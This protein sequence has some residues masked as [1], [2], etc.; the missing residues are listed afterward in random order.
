MTPDD[1]RKIYKHFSLFPENDVNTFK[2]VGP[3]N[4][5]I[6]SVVN[7]NPSGHTHSFNIK[8]IGQ[9]TES[10]LQI[11]KKTGILAE[12]RNLFNDISKKI[13]TLLQNR[14]IDH[15][16]MHKLLEC[17]QLRSILKYTFNDSI[18]DIDLNRWFKHI[19]QM[20][21]WNSQTYENKNINFSVILDTDFLSDETDN[22]S[23]QL[24]NFYNDDMLKVLTN[25]IDTVLKCD[26]KGIIIELVSCAQQL[27]TCDTLGRNRFCVLHKQ[28]HFEHGP[29]IDDLYIHTFPELYSEGK[30][31]IILTNNGDILIIKNYK[32]MFAKRNG[33]WHTVSLHPLIHPLHETLGYNRRFKL[34][35]AQTCLDVSCRHSGGCFGIINDSTK[36]PS[37]V[38]E[39]DILESS[40]KPRT[41]LL[42]RLISGRRFQD[43]PRAI[44]QEL[45]AIDGAII[46]NKDGEILAVGAILKL[47]VIPR[48]NRITGGRS[49]AAQRLACFGVGIKISADG[50]IS[51][52]KSENSSGECQT[53]DG[54]PS[55]LCTIGCNHE[56]YFQLF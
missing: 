39:E 11:Y 38:N 20:E 36:L 45:A 7:D 14:D 48:Q 10:E 34:A 8:L 24:S 35:L 53:H 51:A 22:T 3:C 32:I 31:L 43:I 56:K 23:L 18:D 54:N 13:N 26:K 33:R 12:E 19:I 29:V 2:L 9:N 17:I 5:P 6:T 21:K 30:I 52:W 27:F 55:D 44:R 46:F 40:Q 28:R 4:D 37:L 15:F 25:G 16:E 50:E 49:V 47:K 42:K 41:I 1:I